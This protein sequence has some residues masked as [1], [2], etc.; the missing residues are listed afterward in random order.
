MGGGERDFGSQIEDFG[1]NSQIFE[2][3]INKRFTRTN[4]FADN[5]PATGKI[6]QNYLK[7]NS[8]KKRMNRRK[9][10]E[11]SKK[12]KQQTF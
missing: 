9:R 12:V 1:L 11:I 6:R 8:E 5:D 4:E 2:N 7:A 10:T 3:E